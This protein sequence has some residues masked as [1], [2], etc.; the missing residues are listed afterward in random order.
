MVLLP[1]QE[2][3]HEAVGQTEGLRHQSSRFAHNV[4]VEPIRH[5]K[6]SHVI[7]PPRFAVSSC[8]LVQRALMLRVSCTSTQN[9][10]PHHPIHRTHLFVH[11]SDGLSLK[12]VEKRTNLCSG[13]SVGGF[14]SL[15]GLTVPHEVFFSWLLSSTVEGGRWAWS[16]LGAVFVRRCLGFTGRATTSSKQLI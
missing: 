12:K 14:S 15:A 8:R 6:S 11:L 1:T 16:L 13:L 9:M 10:N 3:A 2:D 4:L 5:Y 7:P